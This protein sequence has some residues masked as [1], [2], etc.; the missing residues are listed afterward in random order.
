MPS[1]LVSALPFAVTLGVIPYI[2]RVESFP[3]GIS[4]ESVAIS[5][6][7]LAWMA[8]MIVP[9]SISSA[10]ADLGENRNDPERFRKEIDKA[11]IPIKILLV[12]GFILGFFCYS[13]LTSSIPEE[14]TNYENGLTSLEVFIYLLSGW[15][16]SLLAAPWNSALKAG[17]NPWMY[18]LLSPLW[19]YLPIGCGLLFPTTDFLE[20]FY[21][22][23]YLFLI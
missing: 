12:A 8:G 18:T 3:C 19:S 7:Q 2:T 21:Q 15:G 6:R 17:E 9:I 13:N 23:T 20:R 5:T 10:I 16:F 1:L 4:L 14:Y 22:Q 11:I